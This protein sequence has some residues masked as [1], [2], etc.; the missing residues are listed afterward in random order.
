M[1]FAL[2]QGINSSTTQDWLRFAHD[3]K[4]TAYVPS[5]KV[6]MELDTIEPGQ[7]VGLPVA[8]RA[9]MNSAKPGVPTAPERL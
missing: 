2:N 3:M 7:A 8:E 6:D 1:R 9:R 5:L 4:I